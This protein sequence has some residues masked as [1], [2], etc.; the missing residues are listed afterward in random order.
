MIVSNE[1]SD[2]IAIVTA[3]PTKKKAWSWPA[4]LEEEKAVSAPI[5]LF[6]EVGYLRYEFK[7]KYVLNFHMINILSLMEC[8]CAGCV[9]VICST[10]P[11]LRAETRLRL[12]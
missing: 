6:K 5:K 2:T 10:R 1:L 11:Y 3:A 12:E 9:C 4:Y 7:E 8:L